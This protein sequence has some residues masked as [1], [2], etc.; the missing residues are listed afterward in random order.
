[1][2]ADRGAMVAGIDASAE[3]LAIARG[4]TPSGDFRIGDM[5]ELPW[6]NASFD[7][8]T[9]FNSLTFATSPADALRE[10]ARVTR[11]GGPVV[12]GAWGDPA[13]SQATIYAA[14]V[15]ALVPRTSERWSFSA[16][17]ALRNLI[18]SAGLQMVAMREVVCASMYRNEEAALRGLLSS[19]PS[20]EAMELAGE[21][22]V[23]D[24]LRHAIAPFRRRDGS[25]RIENVFQLAVA[26]VER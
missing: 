14:A 8:V 25:Y 4:R 7:V 9:A 19:G 18:E 10:A 13:R 20:V 15:R 5:Q 16:P 21:A 6:P 1:M 17:T 11:R 12:I 23:S 3:M 2:A 22:K 26:E 24:A